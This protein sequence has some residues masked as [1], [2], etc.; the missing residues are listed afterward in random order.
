MLY[1][2]IKI[3]RQ[4]VTIT[5][6]VLSIII[7]GSTLLF[8]NSPHIK[9]WYDNYIY[10]PNYVYYTFAILLI[11]VLLII[12]YR[13][14]AI[15]NYTSIFIILLL[16]TTSISIAIWIPADIKHD[17]LHIHQLAVGQTNASQINYFCTFP[18]NLHATTLFHIIYKI[19]HCWRFVILTESLFTLS[20]CILTSLSVYNI[21]RSRFISITTFIIATLLLCVNL[22]SATPHTNCSAM[23][24]HTAAFFLYTTNIRKKIKCPLIL[25][26]LAIGSWLKITSLI[27]LISIIII[28][29]TYKYKSPSHHR[30]MI[31]NISCATVFIILLRA[32][33]ILSYNVFN[34][35]PE[36]NKELRMSWFFY[37][38]QN[39]LSYG[40]TSDE[41]KQDW[42][43]ARQFTTLKERDKALWKEGLS[44]ISERGIAGN[45][46]F[47]IKKLIV[48]Y[49]DALFVNQE[50]QL[51][52]KDYNKKLQTPLGQIMLSQGRFFQ[53][54]AGLNQTLWNTILLLLL[55]S[56]FFIK[57]KTYVASLIFVGLNLYILLFENRACYVYMFVPYIIILAMYT[58]FQLKHRYIHLH[59]NSSLW[60]K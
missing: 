52:K 1:N 13:C 21:T 27:I 20:A 59:L 16:I 19:T 35:T 54:Y 31:I 10:F 44:R 3:I 49:R 6:L 4:F 23:L 24:C 45:I 29:T 34:F 53:L 26:L 37:F 56:P 46:K 8:E 22:R 50:Y 11:G 38:G 12:P 58:L 60:T 25:F 30:N 43:Y 2:I 47:Y 32:L 14:K 40:T 17:H 9:Q 33:P 48:S 36:P 42:K 57:R 28:E 7:V 15:L 55:A 18:F 39:T 51:E 5:F 41:S